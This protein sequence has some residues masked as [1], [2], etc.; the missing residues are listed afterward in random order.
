MNY[1]KIFMLMMFVAISC[2]TAN[3]ANTIK[4]NHTNQTQ[5]S[6]TDYCNILQSN[7]TFADK[8][9]Q[10]ST[11][12][13][14]KGFN[15]RDK[16]KF[17]LQAEKNSFRKGENI[18]I[19]ITLRNTGSELIKVGYDLS[20]EEYSSNNIKVKDDKRQL[21]SLSVEGEKMAK[22]PHIGSYAAKE[23]NPEEEYTYELELDKLYK[24]LARTY[25]VSVS[26]FIWVKNEKTKTWKQ[27][28]IVSNSIEIKITK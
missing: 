26:R 16:Y 20:G 10:V 23:I 24:L 15:F 13:L 27:F 18:I 28:E 6:F 9:L 5:N 1:V 22:I 7:Q 25:I 17:L 2:L 21:V 3:L 14:E 8:K 12:L 11:Q 4:D 19:K